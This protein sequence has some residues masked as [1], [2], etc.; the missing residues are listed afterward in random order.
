MICG[1]AY[2]FKITLIMITDILCI[3]G[4]SFVRSFELDIWPR[5]QNVCSTRHTKT[6]H[7]I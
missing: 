5:L 6:A 4:L 2:N 3:L 7:Q 1:P